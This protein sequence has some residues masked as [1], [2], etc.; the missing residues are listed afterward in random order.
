MKL[1]DSCKN[2]NCNKPI[3]IIEEEG[4]TTIKCHDYVKDV[5][6]VKGYIDPLW[7]TAHKSKALMDLNI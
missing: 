7:I 6:K 3:V 5:D 2:K 4:L 1:C